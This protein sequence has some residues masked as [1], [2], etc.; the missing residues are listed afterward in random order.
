M[1]ASHLAIINQAQSF[2]LYHITNFQTITISNA[3]DDYGFKSW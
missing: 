2:I 3:A 1:G